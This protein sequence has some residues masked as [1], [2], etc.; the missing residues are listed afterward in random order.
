MTFNALDLTQSV[1]ALVGLLFV[2]YQLYQTRKLTKINLIFQLNERLASYAADQETL[3]TLKSAKQF[4]ELPLT[5]R[6]RVLDYVTVF[7]SI[8]SMRRLGALTPRDVHDYFGGRFA[9]LVDNE[10][11]QNAIFF[12]PNLVGSL[13]PIFT[14]HHFWLNQIKAGRLERP[15]TQTPFERFDPTEYQ[16]MVGKG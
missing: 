10:G 14:L 15:P 13:K 3:Q 6:E 7:E 8:E 2:A 16:R 11:L 9:S 1:I 12:N 5:T 4:N